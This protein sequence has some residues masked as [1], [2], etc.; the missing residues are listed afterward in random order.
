MKKLFIVFITVLITAL[1]VS[2]KDNGELDLRNVL[3][4]RVD[5]SNVF[6]VIVKFTNPHH[7]KILINIPEYK[8]TGDEGEFDNLMEQAYNIEKNIYEDAAYNLI[9]KLENNLGAKIRHLRTMSLGNDLIEITTTK[10]VNDFMKE[11][12]ALQ[13]VK[14]AQVNEAFNVKKSETTSVVSANWSGTFFNDPWYN[15]QSYFGSF[16]ENKA[17]SN[18][19]LF[20]QNIE[21][22]LGRKVRIAIID[23]GSSNHED[24]PVDGG[25]SFVSFVPNLQG[26][27][28]TVDRV[29]DHTDG[30]IDPDTGEFKMMEHG[31]AVASVIGA[32]TDN[33]LGMTGAL[34]SDDISLI[35]AKVCHYKGCGQNDIYDGIVWAAG[36]EVAGIPNIDQKV[37]IIN[38]SLGG[39][40]SAGCSEFYQEVI[41]FAVEQGI[42]VVV[43]AGNE[44]MEAENISPANC[45]NTI[46]VGS[47]AP[48]TEDKSDF[49]NYG[50]AVDITAAGTG[51]V[52]AVPNEDPTQLSSEY[53]ATNGTSFA[54]PLVASIAAGL[55]MKYPELTPL[56]IERI[57]EANSYDILLNKKGLP[58][59]CKILGCG[60]GTVDALASLM[61]IDNLFRVNASQVAHVYENNTDTRYLEEM[62][63]LIPVCNLYQAEF[64]SIGTQ[65][66]G[67]EYNIYSYKGEGEITAS[68][69]TF[70]KTVD[71][72]IYVVNSAD[73]IAYQACQ[74]GSC[75]NVIEM[76]KE[77]A[78]K[79]QYCRI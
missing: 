21:N 54:T 76:T 22:K 70:I 20:K 7:H 38:V 68:N 12:K 10:S 48:H 23:S 47:V 30:N 51:I 78:Y 19:E 66:V 50:S 77:T 5:D 39:G 27:P 6:Q 3:M 64:G 4:K 67:I 71:D 55:K 26:E 14:K 45:K 79:P 37:D 44:R 28:V 31:T 36:G 61:A 8:S 62:D 52:V 2:A 69:A 15:S 43:A 56:Q 74:N 73:R 65:I 58:S 60:K 75:G 34:N 57:L 63:K 72:P 35:F 1:S 17:N 11:F 32:Y 53:K 41:D 29:A 16:D 13:E 59:D 46:T 42:V 40:N 24:L 18:F 33:G 25:Y 9:E 49:S